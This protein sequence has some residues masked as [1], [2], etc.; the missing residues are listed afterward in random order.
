MYQSRND[1]QSLLSNKMYGYIDFIRL[2]CIL[3]IIGHTHPEI[4]LVFFIYVFMV[5]S[6]YLWKADRK[7]ASGVRNKSRILIYP[8]LGWGVPLLIILIIQLIF[9]ADS[10]T[11]DIL[12][13][14]AMVLWE[15]EKAKAPFT[16]FWCFTA[17]WFSEIFYRYITQCS[18]LAYGIFITLSLLA[19]SFFGEELASLPLGMGVAFCSLVFYVAGHGLRLLQTKIVVPWYLY[20]SLLLLGATVYLIATGAID[21][22][23]LKSGDFGTL[24]LS[25]WVYSLL[26]FAWIA[27]AEVLYQTLGTLLERPIVWLIGLA[28]PVILFHSVPIWFWYNVGWIGKEII[29]KVPLLIICLTCLLTLTLFVKKLSPPRVQKILVP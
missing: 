18:S 27:N 4:P 21:P 25:T 20:F 1:R 8:Y 17:V 13:T 10:A 6:G 24:V 9:F 14:I 26:A 15:G 2:V 5:L 16:A 3:F 22:M 28:T 12:K 7:L 29:D 19:G 11:L 23:V